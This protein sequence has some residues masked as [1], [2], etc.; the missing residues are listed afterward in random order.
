M[1]LEC[2]LENA[3]CDGNMVDGLSEIYE[4]VFPTLMGR[5]CV[6]GWWQGQKDL[7]ECHWHPQI[8][9]MLMSTAGDGFNILRPANLDNLA[10][11]P[12]ATMGG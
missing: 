9:G 4:Q 1:L 11:D 7:K 5:C 3:E 8:Q 12:D 6:D 2:W 10:A